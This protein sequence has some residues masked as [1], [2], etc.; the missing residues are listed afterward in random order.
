[1]AFPRPTAY[2]VNPKKKNRNM[3]I[4]PLTRIRRRRLKSTQIAY[5]ASS[6]RR[7]VAVALLSCR[8]FRHFWIA[9]SFSFLSLLRDRFVVVTALIFGRS[10][11]VSSFLHSFYNAVSLPLHQWCVGCFLFV[12][13]LF[14]HCCVALQ[15]RCTRYIIPLGT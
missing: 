2:P 6:H 9:V 13:S 5:P 14:R 10:L 8:R 12:L 11:V 7:F 15:T 1:M 3:R 4:A